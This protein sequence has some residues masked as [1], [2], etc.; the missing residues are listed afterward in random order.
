MPVL[1]TILM[2]AS[3]FRL[4]KKWK[5]PGF[6][7]PVVLIALTARICSLCYVIFTPFLVATKRLDHGVFPSVRRLVGWFVK[8][9][10]CTVFCLLLS[11]LSMTLSHP[12]VAWSVL[13][14]YMTTFL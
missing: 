10:A 6:T 3:D 2:K 4:K 14:L 9:H 7:W 12:F 11:F 8:R 13:C 5:R 1:A